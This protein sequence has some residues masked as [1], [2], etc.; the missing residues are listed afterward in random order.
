MQ[1]CKPFVAA[2]AAIVLAVLAAGCVDFVEEGVIEGLTQVVSDGI[3]SLVDLV[4]HGAL[5]S[6]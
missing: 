5:S 2:L 6:G 1:A 4:V 3:A